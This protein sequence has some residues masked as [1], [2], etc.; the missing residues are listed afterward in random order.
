M[1][2]PRSSTSESCAFVPTLTSDKDNPMFRPDPMLF[3]VRKLTE[4]LK[5]RKGRGQALAEALTV[6]FNS[7]E[8][9]QSFPSAITET[10][11][12]LGVKRYKFEPDYVDHLTLVMQLVRNTLNN[13]LQV[14]GK[15][16]KFSYGKSSHY[17]MEFSSLVNRHWAMHLILES[18][19]HRLLR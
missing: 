5:S 13:Y 12:R 1:D 17:D 19:E 6:L 15:T 2:V 14:A 11:D 7:N 10:R 4:K 18:F 8:R 3:K 16:R 9:D